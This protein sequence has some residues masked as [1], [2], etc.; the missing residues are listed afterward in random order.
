MSTL[1]DVALK[2]TKQKPVTDEQIE[3]ALAWAFGKVSLRAA[4]RAT[5]KSMNS[6]NVVYGMLA[7]ALAEY[8]R[9]TRAGP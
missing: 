3:L 2:E 5:G 6:P 8:V 4:A 7:R 9:R 1:L